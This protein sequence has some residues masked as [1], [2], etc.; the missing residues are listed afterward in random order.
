MP[1]ATSSTPATF[2]SSTPPTVIPSAPDRAT[3]RTYITG[4]QAFNDHSHG[5]VPLTAANLARYTGP[6]ATTSY[7]YRGTAQAEKVR[8]GAKSLGFDLPVQRERELL[9]SYQQPPSMQRFSQDNQ[10]Q[11]PRHVVQS[12]WRTLT[13]RDPLAAD[14]EAEIVAIGKRKQRAR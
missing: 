2:G 7:A 3:R 14:I 4:T 8:A 13:E 1:S 10:Q 9:Q 6:L 11:V 12:D 5:Q